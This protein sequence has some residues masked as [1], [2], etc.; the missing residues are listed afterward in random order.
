MHY[1]SGW[2][3]KRLQRKKLWISVKKIH[4]VGSFYKPP[5]TAC[6]FL[7]APFGGRPHTCHTSDQ[8]TQAFLSSPFPTTLLL[9]KIK[10]LHANMLLVKL[11]KAYR[12][13]VTFQ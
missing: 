11:I 9:K 6:L 8:Q 5:G 10:V 3:K 12:E 2:K 7:E 4:T 1:F 13:A